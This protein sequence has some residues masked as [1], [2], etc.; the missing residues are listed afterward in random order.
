[1]YNIIYLHEWYNENNPINTYKLNYHK[2]DV[3]Q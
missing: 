1:M 2:L 3:M